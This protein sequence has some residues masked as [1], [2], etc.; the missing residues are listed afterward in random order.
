MESELSKTSDGQ[1]RLGQAKDRLD[2]R[3]AEIGQA[4]IDKVMNGQD[5]NQ[6][7]QQEVINENSNEGGRGSRT[8]GPRVSDP[9]YTQRGPIC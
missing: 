8:H 1:E 7:P 9:Q 2:T 3:V 5:N 4:E 6:A